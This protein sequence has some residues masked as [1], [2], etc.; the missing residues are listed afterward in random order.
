MPFYLVPISLP[1]P[2]TDL[3]S[4]RE[5]WTQNIVGIYW[6][7]L[8]CAAIWSQALISLVLQI[9]ISKCFGFLME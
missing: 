5:N 2:V 4:Q 6:H 8:L 9:N 1:T 7:A 3:K